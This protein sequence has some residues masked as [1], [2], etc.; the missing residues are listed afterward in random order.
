MQRARLISDRDRWD[1]EKQENWKPVELLILQGSRSPISVNNLANWDSEV[2]YCLPDDI[3]LSRLGSNTLLKFPTI[4]TGKSGISTQK[5]SKSFSTPGE[6]G[7]RPYMVTNR[8]QILL[9][10]YRKKNHPPN[11][12]EHALRRTEL[13]CNTH[14]PRMRGI[15]RMVL[16]RKTLC[17]WKLS[18]LF[19]YMCLLQAHNSRSKAIKISKNRLMFSCA[20]QV[21]NIPS[22]YITFSLH[23]KR[24]KIRWKI[25]LNIC[26]RQEKP[27]HLIL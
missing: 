20:I 21:S 15:T 11:P 10:E 5:L 25:S 7:V 22:N 23:V 12:S 8:Q 17:F 26:P 3:H 19:R 1:L 18:S 6:Y 27:W 24:R 14:T 9:K 13:F 4:N 16:S 2:V